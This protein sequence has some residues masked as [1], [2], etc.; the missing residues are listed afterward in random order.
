MCTLFLLG[1]W[2]LKSWI[3]WYYLEVM[4]FICICSLLICFS[5]LFRDISKLNDE[6]FSDEEKVRG[7][8]GLLM[9]GTD[10][11]NSRK[12]CTNIGT[13]ISYVRSGS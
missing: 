2:K 12:V 4:L 6:W 9:N 8:V 13:S 11:H 1:G 7:I 10:F 3:F 5:S